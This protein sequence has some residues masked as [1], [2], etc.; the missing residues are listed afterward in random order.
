MPARSRVFQQLGVELVDVF[1]GVSKKICQVNLLRLC[2]SKLLKSKLRFVAIDFDARVD[3]DEI[4]AADVLCRDIKLIPHAGFDGAAAVAELEAQI[5]LALAG[6]AN[7]FFVNEEK[8]SD[9][10]FGVEIGDERRLHVPD[11]EP[12]RLPKRRNFLWPFL[13]LVTSGVALTS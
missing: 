8:S 2:E 4:V 7:F 11:T 12:E 1:L 13:F 10:L 9:A 5:G 6:V 3:L